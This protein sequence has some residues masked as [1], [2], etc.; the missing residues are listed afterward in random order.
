MQNTMLYLH[1]FYK[2]VKTGRR[3]S[4][5]FKLKL[6]I[7]ILKLLNLFNKIY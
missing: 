7:L 3:H 5:S 1:D 4:V 2:L 6:L